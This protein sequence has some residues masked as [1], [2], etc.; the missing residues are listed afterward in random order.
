MGNLRF[1][2]LADTNVNEMR[3][4]LLNRPKTMLYF[5]G[6]TVTYDYELN[7]LRKSV[8]DARGVTT[9]GYDGQNR[10][11]RI[12][13]PNGQAVSYTYD[14][15]GNRASMT[16][17]AGTLTYGYDAVNHLKT[18]SNTTSTLAS[19]DYDPVGLRTRK[20][21][22]NGVQ[23]D[24][25]YDTL[26]RLTGIVSH[27]GPQIPLASYQS[28]LGV[29]GNR[30]S[31]TEQDGGRFDWTYDDT[32]RLLTETRTAGI[33]ANLL[34]NGTA[35]PTSGQQPGFVNPIGG[36]AENIPAVQPVQQVASTPTATATVVPPNAS[37]AWQTT[38]SYDKTGNRLTKTESGTTTYYRYNNLDQLLCYGVNQAA[39]VGNCA[40]QSS[41]TYDLRG[42]LTTISDSI[43]GATTYAWDAK[44]RLNSA[45]VNGTQVAAF[46]YDYAGHR[47]QQVNGTNVT[48]YLWDELSPYGDV[49]QEFDAANV[50]TAAYVLGG[51][52]LIAQQ[53][54]GATQF[55][56]QDGQMSVRLLTD[57]L[58]G[59]V[60]RYT[61][62][63]YGMTR[64]NVGS[65]TNVYQYTGQQWDGVIG[66]YNLRARYFTNGIMLSRD[67][68]QGSTQSPSSLAKYIY[69][70]NN[71]VNFI[72]PSGRIALGLG[73][74]SSS[75]NISRVVAFASAAGETVGFMAIAC[76]KFFRIAAIVTILASVIS[77]HFD[78]PNGLCFAGRRTLYH[79]TGQ[80]GV[81]GIW[82]SGELWPS[83]GADR[84]RFGPGLYLT[85]ISASDAA[86]ATRDQVYTAL[87]QGD[88]RPAGVWSPP[89]QVYAIKFSVPNT[90]QLK[91]DEMARPPFSRFANYHW[92]FSEITSYTG[93]PLTALTLQVPLPVG[94]RSIQFLGE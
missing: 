19:Y 4:D 18:V 54:V 58:G 26:N 68:Y 85:E 67:P 34:V 14:A 93:N 86:F 60:N 69:A 45:S 20:L 47:V 36:G 74:Y 5:D 38:F 75:L 8:T 49:I 33:P 89:S 79:I 44:D 11:N 64:E 73:G 90:D 2:R 43:N 21:L 84:A 91:Y 7:G 62:D 87:N 25:T 48:N 76:V 88:L 40:G 30:L 24:Y 12:T 78:T 92:E 46:A 61:Y 23:T 41:Q 81:E 22:L 16:S 72:D 71:P 6:Q 28:Q 39:V 31:V 29:A 77:D 15:A 51:T 56:L 1:H 55:Y 27:K 66:L 37:P 50:Q 63:A 70:L 17:P 35:T 65:A 13:Q 82:G 9:F 3:Y 83:L 52:E 32:Y 80:S 42:N 10:T 53:R 59:V 57:G 94:V